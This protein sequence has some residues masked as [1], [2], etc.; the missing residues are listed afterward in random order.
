MASQIAFELQEQERYRI[1]TDLHDTTMQDILLVRRRLISFINNNE[2][3]QQVVQ[4][5]KHLDLVNESLRQSCFELNPHLLQNIGLVQ[6]IQAT[7]DLDIGLN[8]YETQFHVE[9]ALIIERLDIDIKSIFSVS[10]KSLCTMPRSIQTPPK[11]SLH[12]LLSR[13]TYVYFTGMMG[14]ASIPKHSPRTKTSNDC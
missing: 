6:T 7:L 4:A 12:W 1:A 14:L 3:Q 2:D 8:E 11:S 9:G 5:I 10:F 13:I